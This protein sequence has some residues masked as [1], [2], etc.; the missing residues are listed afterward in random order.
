MVHI[1]EFIQNLFF[2]ASDEDPEVRK[3]VCRA[4]VMLL[5]VRL[6]RLVPQMN[7]IIDYMLQRTQVRWSECPLLCPADR[8]IFR[9]RTKEWR[10]RPASS[11]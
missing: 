1:D 2:L 11:G 4:I 7:N 6:D 3:N 10:W 9:I 8:L 5:E